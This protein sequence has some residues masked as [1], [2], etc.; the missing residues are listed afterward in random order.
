[1]VATEEKVV[2]EVTDFLYQEAELLDRGAHDEWLDLLAEDI[3]YRMPVRVTRERGRG[4]VFSPDMG[5]FIEDRRTLQL[6]VDRLKTDFAWA[7]NPP[8]R[9]RRFVSNVRVT[10]GATPDQVAV[11]SYFLLYRNRGGPADTD[12][13]AGERHDLLRRSEGRWRLARRTIYVDQ[14]TLG[15][16][17]LSVFL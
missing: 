8:S 6:R 11:R 15:T 17:N 12:M 7:E 5:F 9:T 1:M 14:T 13:I 16:P 3:Q 4:E 10:P 2:R